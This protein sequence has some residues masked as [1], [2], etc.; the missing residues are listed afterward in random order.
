MCYR[1]S[2]IWELETAS[3]ALAICIDDS[4]PLGFFNGINQQEAN[5]TCH[6]ESLNLPYQLIASGTESM[7]MFNAPRRFLFE[8]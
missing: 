2:C 4:E 6:Y 1:H 5:L 8:L 7:S 3:D